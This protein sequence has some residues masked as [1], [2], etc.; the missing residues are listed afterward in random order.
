M[1]TRKRFTFGLL[2]A[3]KNFE[4]AKLAAWA[5]KIQTSSKGEQ[6]IV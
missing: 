1:R 6:N 2:A 3:S 4:A 5:L